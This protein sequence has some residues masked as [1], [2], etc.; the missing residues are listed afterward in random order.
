MEFSYNGYFVDLFV[1]VSNLVA[2]GMYRKFGY[3][4]FRRVNGYYSSG[5]NNEEDAFG[6]FFL[7][8]IG[9]I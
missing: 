3:S 7:Y 6:M 2:I 8:I 4:V 1:R 5:D 9:I